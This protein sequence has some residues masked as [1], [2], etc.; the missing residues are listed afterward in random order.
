MNSV[1][2]DRTAHAFRGVL[3]GE[4]EEARSEPYGVRGV[5]PDLRGR[6]GVG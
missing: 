2:G 1:G 6:T 4:D 5:A 3:P